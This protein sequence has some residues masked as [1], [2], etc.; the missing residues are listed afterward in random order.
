M[1]IRDC[2]NVAL[3]DKVE[4]L[5]SAKATGDKRAKDLAQREVAKW[6]RMK[7]RVDELFAKVEDDLRFESAGEKELEV[8]RQMSLE[9]TAEKRR[10]ARSA[11]AQLSVLERSEKFADEK[12][13]SLALSFLGFDER[14]AGIGVGNTADYIAGI[15]FANM[16]GFL[17]KHGDRIVGRDRNWTNVMAEV[18]GESTGDAAAKVMAD[19]I[20]DTFEMIRKMLFR[21]GI[22]VPKMDNFFPQTHDGRMMRK[23]GKQGWKEFIAP[24][25][26]RTKLFDENGEVLTEKAVDELLDSIYDNVVT[27]GLSRW[28]SS[29]FARMGLVGRHSN[30]R[31]LHFKTA[32]DFIDYDRAFGRTR[33]DM[34]ESLTGYVRA[35]SRDIA[36]ARIM[37]P[38]PDAFNDAMTSVIGQ[39]TKNRITRLREQAKEAREKGNVKQAEKL[40]KKANKREA[41]A[42][43][44]GRNALQAYQNTW[45]VVS[46]AANS[47][48]D[49]GLAATGQGARQ[50]MITTSLG[51]AF[52][53]AITD[54]AFA[55]STGFMNGTPWF[56]GIMRHAGTFANQL[57]TQSRTK[58]L[59]RMGFTVD[60]WQTVAGAQNRWVGEEVGPGMLRWMSD[61]ML[62]VT[63]LT[64]WTE[65]GRASFVLEML[66][67]LT[68][69][70]ALRFADFDDRVRAM[71]ARHDISE[72]DWDVYR[73]TKP[74]E[75][76]ERGIDL[77]RPM[78]VGATDNEAQR[79]IAAKFHALIE[80]E[81]NIAIPSVTD[82]AR[83]IAAFGTRAGTPIGEITRSA[84]L[85]KSFPVT[86]VHG[87]LQR[88]VFGKGTGPAT[89]VEAMMLLAL[90]STAIAAF[91]T[92]ANEI[93]KGRTPRPMDTSE[94][95]IAFWRDAVWRAG[96]AGFIGDF[97]FADYS[98]IPGRMLQ[99]IAGP[100][101]STA[102]GITE[103]ISRNAWKELQGEESNIARDFARISYQLMPGRSAWFAQV[104]L[105]KLV[106]DTLVN[107]SDPEAYKYF[108]RREQD[109]RKKHGN[110]AFPGLEEGSG[111]EGLSN[112]LNTL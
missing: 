109:L 60:T 59:N 28:D 68:D 2:L 93:A 105:R 88:L 11:I 24:R 40:E 50:W 29:G 5:T 89:K 98:G 104:F 17:I 22:V 70:R 72:A 52:W 80:D 8:A 46:S 110:E 37:G 76:T 94:Q 87:L 107:A 101:W 31:I 9:L 78:D 85:F 82:R 102:G 81:K 6:N 27:G 14:V 53:S 106:L 30:Q 66:G 75:D 49:E 25:L 35:V 69:N 96:F 10:V 34:F 18:L 16:D 56:R 74:W 100:V 57:T 62:R 90:G 73:A 4:V 64:P 97:V 12:A 33:G 61:R 23:A 65:A 54:T 48:V 44:E 79:T 38:R 84:M 20:R 42:E 91:S 21:E 7:E 41:G 45:A 67:F 43:N 36:I 26:D 15:A 19:S 3:A 83:A 58:A 51:S 47:P 55:A 108:Q 111:I 92:Q 103:A 95:G 99:N 13:K 71:F 39:H 1:S 32:K 112:F 77:I 86:I 63:L